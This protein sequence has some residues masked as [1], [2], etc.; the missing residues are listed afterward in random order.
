MLSHW[1]IY[2]MPITNG[3]ELK[4][5]AEFRNGLNFTKEDRGSG[6]PIIGV[7]D[8]SLQGALDYTLLD[9]VNGEGITSADDYLRSGDIVFVRSNGN[10]DLV[11]R[12]IFIRSNAPALFSGFCIRARI[13][14]SK[15]EPLFSYYY[16]KTSAFKKQLAGT[17]GSNIQNLNQTV[18]GQIR[19]P[20]L[21]LPE[22]Q[23]I[24]SVLSALDAKI[25]L[26]HRINAELEALA[27][28]IYDYWFVQF[29]FPNTKGL[30]YKTSGGKMIWNDT[31]KREIPE[32]WEVLPLLQHV[33]VSTDS[34]YPSAE[35]EK[36]FKHL[37]IP[38]F[39][40]T[41]T[42]RLEHGDTIGSNKFTVRAFDLLVSKLNPWF[43]RVVADTAHDDLICSTEFVVWRCGN[44][45]DQAYL[46]AI[47][48]NQQ[49]I[50]YCIRSATGTSN[51]HKRVNPQ[52][53]MRYEVPYST[54]IAR[55]FGKFA[56]PLLQKRIKNQRENHELS[57]LRDWLL[58]LLMNGQVQSG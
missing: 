15:L 17:S 52:V 16:T 22:Q 37:S 6:C 20:N 5:V 1:A 8:F 42:F 9:K 48:T 10:K 41:G 44:L 14:A 11:G 54:E 25:D 40:E 19:L 39:D 3:I 43:N 29:D 46:Y 28:T 23:K 26:N 30:P 58:P 24:A 50:D 32:G 45:L 12:S 18:L 2:I 47:A 33:D 31:L 7:S 38:G 34:V 53:M 57:T 13:D 21:P 36:L 55:Q 49:F 51:S 4:S 56:A 35:P 27:K